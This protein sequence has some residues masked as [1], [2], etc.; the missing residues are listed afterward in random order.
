MQILSDNDI[1]RYIIVTL[2]V[3]LETPMSSLYNYEDKF[4]STKTFS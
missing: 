1:I 3:I 2:T 4:V